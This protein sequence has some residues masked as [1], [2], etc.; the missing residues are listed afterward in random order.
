MNKK[1]QLRVSDPANQ[2]GKETGQDCSKQREVVPAIPRVK[3]T[4]SPVFLVERLSVNGH[5]ITWVL[6]DQKLQQGVFQL[7]S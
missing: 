7:H 2:G 1:K 3:N 4:P 6:D 5:N